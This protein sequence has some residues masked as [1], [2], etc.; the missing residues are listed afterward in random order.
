MQ[1]KNYQEDV[2]MHVIDV[3]LE[4]SPDLRSDITF[5]NDVAAYV[6][7]RVPPK[8]IMSER[9]FTRFVSL[10]FLNDENGTDSGLVNLL[11]LMAI[12]N[13]GIDMVKERRKTVI[14]SG[15]YSYFRTTIP[16]IKNIEYMHNFPQFIGRVKDSDSKKPVNNACVTLFID[17]LKAQPAEPGWINPY[18]TTELTKGAYSFW[19]RAIKNTAKSKRSKVT[20]TIEHKDYKPVN[21]MH[22]ITTDGVFRVYN[23]IHGTSIVNLGTSFLAPRT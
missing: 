6:L 3:A 12:V 11:E 15:S 13:R 1:L 21:L 14:P 16:D 10:H 7:N 8:Y 20:I 4:N 19:P 9:G 17:G 2:V 18:Y 22:E 23:Y 5:V